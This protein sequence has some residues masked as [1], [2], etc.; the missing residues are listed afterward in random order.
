MKLKYWLAS[1]VVALSGL[2]SCSDV[3]DV[4]PDGTLTMEEVFSD[5]DKV[6]AFLNSCYANLSR[7]GY[8]YW[9]WTPVPT[10]LSDDGWSSWDGSNETVGQIYAGK[11]SASDHPLRD[12][13][14]GGEQT[15]LWNT[16]NYWGRYWT[17]IRLCS[18]FLEH[19]DNAAVR[20]EV[21][22]DRLRAEAHV[23]RA[24]FY[25]ELVKWFGKLPI[26]KR[27]LLNL[28]LIFLQ[29]TREPVYNVVKFIE[30]DCDAAIYSEHLHGD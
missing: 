11:E 12:A 3:L 21:E 22:R 8:F 14:L 1:S 13:Y 7:K 10:A 30:E 19:I 6:G 25:S 9:G 17:Q 16:N 18:Q 26:L 23:L 24:Y 5:P 4:A 29:L 15:W 20:S 28:M 27:V 2:T